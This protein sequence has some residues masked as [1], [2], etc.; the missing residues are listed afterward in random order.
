[1][2][3]LSVPALSEDRDNGGGETVS[4]GVSLPACELSFENPLKLLIV[5]NRIKVRY[6]NYSDKESSNHKIMFML[7]IQI[8]IEKHTF[9]TVWLAEEI[10]GDDRISI[11]PAV[12]LLRFHWEHRYS[13]PGAFS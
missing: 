2:Y 10:P 9:E 6:F 12:Y 11:V 5:L 4:S 13:A 8:R 7:N 1:M 3:I